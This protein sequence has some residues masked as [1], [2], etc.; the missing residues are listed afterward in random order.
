MTNFKIKN[1]LK[2][3]NVKL[4]DATAYQV[5]NGTWYM[6]L[7]YEYEDE[8]GVIGDI[9]QRLNFLFSAESCLLGVMS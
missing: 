4:V 5:E 2:V 7:Q 3:K 9:I 1:N 6:E 8:S